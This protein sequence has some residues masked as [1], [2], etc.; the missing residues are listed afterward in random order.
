MTIKLNKVRKSKREDFLNPKQDMFLYVSV[1]VENESDRQITVS[2]LVN[3]ELADQEGVRYNVTLST[4]AKGQVDG[5]LSPGQELTG[6]LVFD[7]PK[8]DSYDLIYK[9][10]FSG[11]QTI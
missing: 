8:S 4:K 9:N 11:S 6:E 3:F 2:S 10:L 7:V 5:T 1:T